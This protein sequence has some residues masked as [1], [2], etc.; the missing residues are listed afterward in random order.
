MN[1]IPKWIADLI[2]HDFTEEQMEVIAINWFRYWQGSMTNA[3]VQEFINVA[4][5]ILW[6]TG[7]EPKNKSQKALPVL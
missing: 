2:A 4:H 1:H 5:A 3:S 7:H 6:M